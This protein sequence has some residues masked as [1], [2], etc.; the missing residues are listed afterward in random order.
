MKK[1]KKITIFI[2]AALTTLSSFSQDKLGHIDVQEIL[3]VMPE[4]KAAETEMQ[5][6]ALD[7][8]K[9]SKALQSE[10]QA[11]F[12]DYQANVDSYSDIIRQDKEK[13]I[14]DLQQRIQAFE[15]NAQAQLEEKRQKLLTPITKAVQ[16]AI[17]EVASEGGY[18]YIF[19]TEIL[20][21]SSKSN[22]VGLL[23]KKKLGL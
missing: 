17:Q 14:Q 10:I 1:M 11:K 8:E 6:F 3:V 20:L 19:T 23:V 13:E 5:N 16:D 22:D 12:E 2:I 18:T 4:Y 21:F 9:T 7:L 15:Q